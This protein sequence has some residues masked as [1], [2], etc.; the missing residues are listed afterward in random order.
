M[1]DNRCGNCTACC[2]VFNIAEL[3]KPAGK[4]CTHCAIGQGCR[5]YPERP[6]TCQTFECL[7]LQSQRRPGAVLGPELRPDN[8]KVVFAPSTSPKVMTAVTLPDAPNAWQRPA[9]QKLIGRL[10]AAGVAVVVG[11]PA[12]TERIMLTREGQHKVK[13]T[14]PDEKGLQWNVPLD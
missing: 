14:E 4:W 8:C 12:A 6:A 2:R 1:I 9:P 11:A 13:L 7:W 3:N 10:I 5:I